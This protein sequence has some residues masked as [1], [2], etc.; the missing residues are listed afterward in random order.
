MFATTPMTLTPEQMQRYHAQGFV[1]LP[2]IIDDD[3]I[4]RQRALFDRLFSPPADGG[5]PLYYDLTGDDPD[6][7]IDSTSVPQLLHPSH[8]VPELPR[9]AAWQ[10]ALDIAT[11]LLDLG[12]H[13]RDDLIVRDHMIV[14]P[15]RSTGDTPW[16]QDEAY[17][18][19]DLE[20]Q[21]LSVWI[22]LQDTTEPMGC[23]QF[24]PGSHRGEV[25][26]HHSWKNDPRIIA[27]E[28]DD[29]HVE[30]SKVVACP[31]AAGGAT[32]HHDRTLHYTGGNST[33]EPRRALILTIGTPP[34][35]REQPR[36]FY[37]NRK[38]RDYK[39]QI[40]KPVDKS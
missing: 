31:L 6:K 3:E 16:H 29:G 40:V 26:P 5:K 39:Q 19:E 30:K 7:Q 11:E 37:W 38:Q 25:L 34:K 22:A 18:Q 36:D 10:S 8:H 9:S 24:V 13:T 4:A 14:K 17:W 15:A 20:Y 12:A 27:L 28:V 35:K 21:E 23:M 2:P 33:D 32:V 1:V